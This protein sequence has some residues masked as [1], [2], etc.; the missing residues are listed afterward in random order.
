[1]KALRGET[2]IGEARK[3]QALRARAPVVE[4]ARL[5]RF[6]AGVD[7]FAGATLRGWAIDLGAPLNSVT[8]ALEVA[9]ERALVFATNEHRADIGAVLK[10]NVAGFALDFSSLPDAAARSIVAALEGEPRDAPPG[11]HRLA[12]RV[13]ADD[14]L[15]ELR[16]AGVRVGDVLAALGHGEAPQAVPPP[17]P[18]RKAPPAPAS[19][20]RRLR[21]LLAYLDAEGDE[22]EAPARRF[23]RRLAA[24]L[25]RDANLSPALKRHAAEIAPLFDPFFYLDRLDAP[26]EATANP[27]LHYLL[28][29]WR[30]GVAP[31]PLFSPEHYRRRR[32]A[33]TGDPLLDFLHEGADAD[34]HPLFDVAFYRARHLGEATVN[35]LR[36]YLDE[37]APARL[38]PSSLFDTR[39]FLD[40][41]GFGD[42]IANPLEHYLTTPACFGYTLTPGFDANLYR[43]QIEIERGERLREPAHVHYLTRGFLDET[44]LPNL[45]FD[46]EFYRQE[47]KLDLKAPALDHYLAEGEAAGLGCHPLFSPT[48]YNSER[49]VEGSVGAL[50]H[51]LAH[52]GEVRSDPRM[53]LAL[54]K[55][56]F[57]LVRDL[58]GERGV[59]TFHV[60]IYR[61]A[62][63]DLAA[64]TDAQLEAHNRSRGAMDGRLSSLTMLMRL[65]D[66]KLRDLPIGFVLEDYVAIYSDLA[67]LESR[68][69]SALYHW[70]R[71]GRQERRLVGRWRFQIADLKLDLPSAAAPLRIAASRDV[72]DVCVLIHAYYPDLLPEL[73]AFAQNFRGVSFDIYI[74]VVDLAWTAQL[75]ATLREICPGAFVMLS[76]DLGRDVGGFTRLLEA[77]DISAYETFAFLHSKKSPHM[78]EAE[79]EFWRR[80]LLTAIAGTPQIAS[81]C[82]AAM[83]ENPKLGLIGAK[84][85]RSQEI[86]RNGAQYEKLL[87]LFGVRGANRDVD[88]ISGFM[89]LARA[90][91]VARLRETLRHLDFEFGGDRDLSFHVDGQ[92]AHGVE[93]AVPALVREMGF[94]I[95]YR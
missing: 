73:I 58:V 25:A 13:E 91:I 7:G 50:E 2:E 67:H 94:E 92:I 71:Y 21:W 32:G 47:N 8:L 78:V 5:P 15:I 41:F 76:N 60:G 38:D 83:K 43:H 51:A 29:G 85:R 36:H 93:R 74:N 22:A 23:A 17:E 19:G 80:D 37:G 70:G 27:L 11:A 53:E 26:Q 1:M 61:D 57:A 30:D 10:D 95:L 3:P 20:T 63:P 4:A 90:P 9:G 49:G 68:F 12:L 79:G 46:P 33:F 66:L 44:L 59:E 24:D 6:V 35:P 48:F 14:T 64:F 77:I 87:D 39:A 81:A 28:A 84:S 34:P 65:A 75:Q 55:R 88:Y 31:H 69:N 16:N 86:G 62:N 42:D 45:L 89:F 18:M 40:A 82:V 52:P 54:D 56:M 72:R